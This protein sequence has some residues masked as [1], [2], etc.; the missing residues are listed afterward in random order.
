MIDDS[1]L[2]FKKYTAGTWWLSLRA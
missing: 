2:G 1:T